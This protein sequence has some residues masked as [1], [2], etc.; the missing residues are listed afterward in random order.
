MIKTGNKK[1]RGKLETKAEEEQP[2][3][4]V[5]ITLDWKQKEL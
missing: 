5:H 3:T 4:K 2:E 1:N